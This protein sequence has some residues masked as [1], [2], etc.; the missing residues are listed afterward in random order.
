M[1]THDNKVSRALIWTAGIAMILFFG[2]GTAAF[3]GWLPGSAGHTGNGAAISMPGQP[4]ASPVSATTPAAPKP[5]IAK[6][7]APKLSQLR[8][9]PKRRWRR[10]NA[11]IAA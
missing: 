9:T 4:P 11:S 5:V 8:N 7:A 1:E 2:A 10:P 6:P 3:M